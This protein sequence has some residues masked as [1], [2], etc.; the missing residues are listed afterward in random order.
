MNI[1]QTT[2]SYLAGLVDGEAYIG[3]KKSTYGMR[4]RRDVYCPTYSERIQIRLGNKP[5]NKKALLLLKKNYG[6]SLRLEPRIYQS[7][8]G[9]KTNLLMILYVAS[10]KIATKIIRDVYPYL[11]IKKKEGKNVLLLR[12]NKESYL[13]KKRGSP[14]G[15]KMSQKVIQ[16]RD[17]LWKELK[18]LH[19]KPRIG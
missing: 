2:I 10:D 5:E 19:Q 7:K 3:I 13:A 14:K 11:I 4:K 17:K 18:Q 9:F 1:K 15:R 8:N 16:Y 6:G 12:K